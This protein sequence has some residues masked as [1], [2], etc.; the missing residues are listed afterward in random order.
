MKTRVKESGITESLESRI[1]RL[2][3]GIQPPESGIHGVE[4]GIHDSLG[5][6]YMGRFNSEATAVYLLKA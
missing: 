5:F 1:H 4:S 2:E 3:F 6:P